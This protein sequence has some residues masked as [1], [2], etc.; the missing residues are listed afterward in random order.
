MKRP[1]KPVLLIRC[2]EIW[3]QNPRK[4]TFIL[5]NA[6]S[7]HSTGCCMLHFTYLVSTNKYIFLSY[8]LLQ[9]HKNCRI[10]FP[11]RIN[12][13]NRCSEQNILETSYIPTQKQEVKQIPVSITRSKIKV[14][15]N[16]KMV[17][18]LHVKS[19]EFA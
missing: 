7:E 12:R 13:Y 19:K 15:D 9:V 10:N 18:S 16:K 8:N 17:F 3:S 2:S 14:T 1:L 11:T 4:N 5:K 6:P